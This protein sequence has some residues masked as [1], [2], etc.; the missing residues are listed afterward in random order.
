VLSL[1][2]FISIILQPVVS[3]LSD[4]IWT[5]FGRR[6]PFV[7]TSFFGVTVCLV[8]LPFMP[9][10]W[11][12]L[13]VYMVYN[14]FADLNSPMEPLKQE[15]IPP[16]ERGRATA[17][18]AWCSN[19]GTMT[20]WFVALGRFDDVSYMGGLAINGETV[21]YCS[22]ALLI[23]VCFLALALWRTLE[24]WMQSKGLGS[25]ARQLIKEMAGI[26]SVDVIVPVQHLGLRLPQGSR[27]LSDVVPKIST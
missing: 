18:M 1:P 25:C 19:L 17:A 6:K 14:V 7:G 5:R 16:H 20:F 2:S 13:A 3:F 24:Q 21:I 27:L 22:G 15:I 23:L 8:L 9:N 12:L 4:R 10:F 11:T 26:K